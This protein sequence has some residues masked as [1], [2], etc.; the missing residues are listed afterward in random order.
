MRRISVSLAWDPTHIDEFLA[1]ARAADEAGVETLWL[2]E[3]FGHDAFSGLALLARETQRAKLG[4]SVVNVYSRT[5]GAL[6]QHFATID[7]LSGGRV[8]V[9]LGASGPGVIERFHGLPFE[10]PK[11]RIRE[12]IALLRA[13]WSKQ[14]FDHP[15]PRFPVRRALVMGARP[16]QPSP[17]IFL[18]TLHPGMVRMTAEESEGWLPNWIP[19]DR[20]ATEIAAARGWAAAAGRD[21]AAFTVR[22]PGVV[23][24]VE[25]EE[26]LMESRARSASML[27][28]FAARNGP[29]YER[30][31]TRQGL[32]EEVAA[33][34]R[35]WKDDGPAA[36]AGLA[37]AIAPEFSFSGSL[38]DCLARIEAQAAAGVDLHDVQ[39]E[40]ATAS[41]RTEILRAL[42]G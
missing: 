36:A 10:A 17:P 11:A 26:R 5:P 34:Q 40:G 8:I 3:G 1:L 12:T 13:Y 14:R 32:G 39:V 18:A 25:D 22:A 7:E 15:G 42:V 16:V 35:A 27:A 23:T 6:A 29:L 41:R 21:P 30:Q 19:R 28:F 9:G 20:L 2:S 38:D 4:T 37:A 24:V 31:F 33:I